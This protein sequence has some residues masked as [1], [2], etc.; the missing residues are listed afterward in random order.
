MQALTRETQ[1]PVII[2]LNTRDEISLL[3]DGHIE[4]LIRENALCQKSFLRQYPGAR[5]K[6]DGMIKY[7]QRPP[8]TMPSE[9]KLA[10]P[11]RA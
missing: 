2:A 3:L 6:S 11:Q 9:L 5:Q 7:S 8:I 1:V 10:N 4:A